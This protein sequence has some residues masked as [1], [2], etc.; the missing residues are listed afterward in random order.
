MEIL[1]CLK[2]PFSGL[3]VFI[4]ANKGSDGWIRTLVLWS[5]KWLLRQLCQNHCPN[6][7]IFIYFVLHNEITEAHKFSAWVDL[8]EGM[9]NVLSHLRP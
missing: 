8:S 5:R 2:W 9:G 4:L 7:N 6:V 1:K 3:F